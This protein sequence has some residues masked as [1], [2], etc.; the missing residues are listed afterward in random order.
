MDYKRDLQGIKNLTISDKSPLSQG[1]N[2]RYSKWV[3]YKSFSELEHYL[4]R[5]WFIK[6]ISDENKEIWLK[7]ATKGG[8][9]K[10]YVRKCE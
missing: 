5:I 3:E 2:L 1:Q 4:S 10:V 9:A 7:T 6:A 8:R